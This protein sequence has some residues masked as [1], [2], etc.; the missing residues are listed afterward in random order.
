VI[1][2]LLLPKSVYSIL[3]LLAGL[4]GL[5]GCNEDTYVDPV[6]LTTVRGRVVYSLDQQPVRN[7]TV[8][9]T[10]G[11]RVVS[12]DSSGAFRFDSVVVGN[13][14]V[15]ASKAGYGTQVATVSATVGTTPVVTLQLTDDK[16]QNRPPTTPALVAPALNSTAQSTTLTLKW[17]STDPN[18]DTLTYNVLLYRAG[19]AT[20]TRSYT[21]LTADSVVVSGLEYN[22]TYLW[23]VIVNDKIN[24]VNG[25]VWSFQTGSYPDYRYVFARRMSGQFQLFGATAAGTVSQL[26]REGSNWR[27]I[28]SPNRQKIAFISNT[29]TEL[30]LYVMNL[31]GSNR[32]QVTSV[33]IAGLAAAD[34]S[35]CWSPD[36]TQLL[37]PSN[38]RLYAVRT[39]G[40]G[41]RVVAQASSGRIWAGCDWTP[42]GNRI[43]ARTTGTSLYDNELS[44]FNS[45]GSATR[46]VYTRRA[47]RVGNPVFSVNGQQLLFSADSTDF[48]NEQGRQ[49]DARL[50]RL[51]LT[52]GAIADLSQNQTNSNQTGQ[53]NKLAGTNDLDPRYS[54]TSASVIFTNTD[55]TGIGQRN[56]YT[57]DAN[58]QNRKLVLSQAEMPYWR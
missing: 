51:N 32:Q 21:G 18:R 13:Y 4:V 12:T 45:D 57:A 44:V 52:T 28:V 56:V 33:P 5:W 10:P 25:P 55:N 39:D 22:T 1:T 47:A 23:Q 26:T 2:R 14:T 42:Q 35:F 38:D 48:Q 8:K 17:T 19:A 6:Q 16:S 53:T 49:L 41:L 30:Q 34:L 3:T 29:D 46:A 31:D 43:A 58:G 54:P 20:P 27:P 50:F 24:T 9:L 15:Q 36:G 11:S 7:A 40:T 37:Y